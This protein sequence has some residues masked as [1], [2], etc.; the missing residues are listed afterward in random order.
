MLRQQLQQHLR[1]QHNALRGFGDYLRRNLRLILELAQDPSSP[2]PTRI[3]ARE[4]DRVG[5]LLLPPRQRQVA[6]ISSLVPAFIT[7]QTLSLDQAVS[8][9]KQSWFEE[10]LDSP[11][12]AT[13]STN[14]SPSP[15]A[16]RSLGLVGSGLVEEQRISGVHK[17]TVVRGELDFPSGQ[18][19]I[20]DCH[21]T[22]VYILAPLQYVYISACSDCTIVVGA[23]GKVVRVER[24][25]KVQ[26]IAA[27]AR[28]VIASCHDCVFHLGVLRA[29]I[30]IGDSRFLKFAPFNTRYER[31]LAHLRDAGVRLDMPNQ[32]DS[33]IVLQG[34]DRRGQLSGPD[35]P[36]AYSLSSST[37]PPF[38]LLPPEEFFPFV[39]PFQGSAGVLAGGVAPSHTTKWG[40]LHTAASKGPVYLF[41]LPPEYERALHKKLGMTSELR[42]KFKQANL[43]KDKE[44]ELNDAI[45]AHFK[46]WLASS[47]MLRQ[48]YDLSNLEKDEVTGTPLTAGNSAGAA[49]PPS[50]AGGVSASRFMDQSPRS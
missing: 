15:K 2:D 27:A 14:S 43:G 12:L 20:T 24:C 41:P 50:N 29:P 35:S 32:W 37:K 16:H 42:H 47:N 8:N 3:S 36:R 10:T 6:S 45:Q 9:L 46:D 23:V 17:G 4:V 1:N 25:D 48:I 34:R 31:Q 22:I 33:P 49:A 13:F 30:L 19:H 21:D 5:F 28:V 38:S 18:L 7:Q 40:Q 11:R 39:V 44:R 26:V